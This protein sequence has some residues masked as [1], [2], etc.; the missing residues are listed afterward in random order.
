MYF[1]L[2][3]MGLV[4][5]YVSQWEESKTHVL[6]TSSLSWWGVT[7]SKLY[8]ITSHVCLFSAT[9]DD[10]PCDR[11]CRIWILP[12]LNDFWKLVSAGN[13]RADG[14]VPVLAF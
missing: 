5:F 10:I 8:V 11:E 2:Q 7:E 4:C 12:L 3:T 13:Q 6:R 1:V 9:C 14:L